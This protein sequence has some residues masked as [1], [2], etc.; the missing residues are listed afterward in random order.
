MDF[1]SLMDRL[2]QHTAENSVFHDSDYIRDG[3]L[4]CGKCQMPKQVRVNFLGTEKI[5]YCTCRCDEEIYQH[6]EKLRQKIEYDNETEHLRRLAFPLCCDF[7]P[8]LPLR[9]DMRKWTFENDNNSNPEIM[10]IARDYVNNFEECFRNGLGFLFY[11]NI[12]SGKSYVSASIANALVEKRYSVLMTTFE[13]IKSDILGTKEKQAVYERLN[14]LALLIIDDLAT[15]SDSGYTSAIIFSVIN[16]RIAAGLPMI[17][18]T[19]LTQEEMSKPKDIRYKRLFSRINGC[20]M[21]V[22]FNG[23]DQ[24]RNKAKDTYA[25]MSKILNLGGKK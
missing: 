6:E 5:Q 14:S 1:G 13:Q 9:D 17:I 7:P 23:P 18:T 19:N 8:N 11:G 4:Y 10:S 22:K 2:S 20:C 12:G 21:T 3:L 15:E 24:R 16:N 25:K